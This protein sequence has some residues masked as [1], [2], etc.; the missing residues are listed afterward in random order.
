MEESGFAGSA[1]GNV[2]V[3][4]LKVKEN[5][6]SLLQGLEDIWKEVMYTSENGVTV[7][8]EMYTVIF[9]LGGDWKFLACVCGLEA[10]SSTYAC[11]WCTCAKEDRHTDKEWS[12]SDTSKGA[13]TIDSIIERS[14][15][16]KKSPLRY[17]CCSEP[18]FQPI[19]VKRVVIDNLHLF[20][21]V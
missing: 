2:P 8:A 18:L 5:Y 1:V 15:L 14:Q 12:I 4:L 7:G 10:A 6:N 20:F 21:C 19:P 16:P 3:C 17:N 11:I 13:C 9:Y